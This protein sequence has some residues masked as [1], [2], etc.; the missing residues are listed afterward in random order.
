[1]YRGIRRVLDKGG[2]GGRRFFCY[3]PH[4]G[5]YYYPQNGSL[6]WGNLSPKK[7]AGPRGILS[8]HGVLEV[9]GHAVQW[10]VRLARTGARPHPMGK[11]V[12]GGV[13]YNP[14][15]N[16]GLYCFGILGSTAP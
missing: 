6:A 1:M 12:E 15:C 10:G 16:T 7:G 3:C 5:A 4:P 2:L 8:P 11:G 13:K 14:G 9:V